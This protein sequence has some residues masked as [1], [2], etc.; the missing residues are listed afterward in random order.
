MA[1]DDWRLKGAVEL[2]GT[3]MALLEE[4]LEGRSPLV[5]AKVCKAVCFVGALNDAFSSST[6]SNW[7]RASLSHCV[8]GPF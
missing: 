8:A 7:S 1:S 6:V 5:I 2:W 3:F 4:P